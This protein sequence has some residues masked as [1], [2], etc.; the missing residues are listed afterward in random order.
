MFFTFVSGTLKYPFTSDRVERTHKGILQDMRAA[1][2]KGEP[3]RGVFGPSPL[4]K[5]KGLDLVWGV[6]PDYMHCV[7]EGVVKQLT[8]VWFS[9]TGSACYIGTMVETVNQRLL[10]ICPPNLFSRLPRPVGERAQWKAK[11]WRY[12]LLYYS[13]PCLN[14][15]LPR[16]YFAHLTLLCE[17]IFLL[18]KKS[19][20]TA[21]LT[22]AEELLVRFA[23]RVSD[24]YGAA[25]E[26]SNMH[27]LL[28]LPKSVSQLG[29]LWATS[30]FPFE[31]ASGL[32]LELITAAKGVA[33]Q[34]GERCVMQQ[35][36]RLM[37]EGASLPEQLR[38][39]FNLFMRFK[40]RREEAALGAPLALV[41]TRATRRAL[42][43][44]F[45]TMPI[46]ERYQRATIQGFHL[47]SIEYKRCKKTCTRFIKMRDEHFCEIRDIFQ[48]KPDGA[49]FLLCKILI[50]SNAN[51]GSAQYIHS[52]LVPPDE[53]SLCI[54]P[55]TDVG[56]V[57]VFIAIQG[58]SYLCDMPNS[59]ERE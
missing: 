6:V 43:D 38:N 47:N 5:L 11:E 25:A 2:K 4:L 37:G 21:D 9:D 51:M 50:I 26:T 44:Y 1:T 32:I 3:V 53:E 24:L 36:L 39:V 7:L 54:Y 34:V 13:L 8:E 57:C 29:P 40:V 28:H 30:M 15:I 42:E 23:L 27:L 12:W 33:Q 56:N 18:L 49:L 55:S 16:Q 35:S 10:G 20:T 31:S 22:T 59:Y 46:L 14:N 58:V 17:A 45:G 52:C 41:P 19:V 48:R